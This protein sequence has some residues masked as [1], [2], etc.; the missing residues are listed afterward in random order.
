LLWFGTAERT[1]GGGGSLWGQHVDVKEHLGDV[2]SHRYQGL[3]LGG[4]YDCEAT[5]HLHYTQ[6]MTQNPGQNNKHIGNCN[7]WLM[8]Q[9]QVDQ[10]A[11]EDGWQYTHYGV[12]V[13]STSTVSYDKTWYRALSL[14]MT[15]SYDYFDWWYM[16]QQAAF[17]LY[18]YGAAYYSAKDAASASGAWTP[19]S[20]I[21]AVTLQSGDRIAAV[22]WEGASRGP[23]I[24]YRKSTSTT[25]IYWRCYT[26][27]GWTSETNFN[28]VTL[29]PAASEPFATFRYESPKNYIYVLWRGTDSK[30]H[31][32]KMDVDSFS[33]FGAQDLGT[34]M[35]T[36]SVPAAAPI[37]YTAAQDR[38]V[39]VFHSLLDADATKYRWTYLGDTDDD[40]RPMGSAF[41]SDA[42]PSLVAYPYWNRRIYFLRPNSSGGSYSRHILY[43]SYTIAGGWTTPS[44]T[45]TN[46]TAM[47][48]ADGN[49]LAN[50]VRTDKG[51]AMAE[52]SV[53]EE[54][55]LH[56][57]F[58]TLTSQLWHGTLIESSA[59]VLALDG[60]RAVPQATLSAYT[61][62]AAGGLAVGVSGDPSLWHFWMPFS[63]S[64]W[65]QYSD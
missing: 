61:S 5:D 12:E 56:F 54:E 26:S 23:C 48:N 37:Y 24:F 62:Q 22:S 9:H 36:R 18:G 15:P 21:G 51:L 58:V 20:M 29:D 60:Y 32:R 13:T 45:T 43:A 7:G 57:F 47:Y 1:V 59:G 35:K 2:H 44:N 63:L 16:L 8:H 31:Y 39:I 55:R 65:R 25:Q 4:G 10:D 11:G 41:N 53:G 52:F 38:L 30:I 34:N 42:P 19:F 28:L 50:V 27:T 17:D 33:V 14:Y 64:Q 49:V 46:L 40:G 3:E 6:F